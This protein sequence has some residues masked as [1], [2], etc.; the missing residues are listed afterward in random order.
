MLVAL[1]VVLVAVPAFAKTSV[2]SADEDG[3]VNVTFTYEGNLDANAVFVA[4]EFNNWSPNHPFW[5]M[6]KKDGAWQVTK[7]LDQGE[8]YQYKFTVYGGG[9]LKWVKDEDASTFE[10]DGFGGQNSVLIAKT[11][12][13]LVPRV[14]E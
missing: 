4:G 12:V 5:R 3:K 6:K 1:V 2:E 11:S 13:D 8:K 10:A 7:K 9:E 14:R